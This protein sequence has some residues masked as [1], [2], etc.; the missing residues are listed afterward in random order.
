MLLAEYDRVLGKKSGN[1]KMGY[2]HEVECESNLIYLNGYTK[3]DP[4]W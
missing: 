1:V 2:G 3:T 4:R